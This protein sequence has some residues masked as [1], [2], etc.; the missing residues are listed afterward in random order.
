M[1]VQPVVRASASNSVR[2]GAVLTVS[3]PAGTVD[4]D[5]VIAF[6]AQSEDVQ[7]NVSGINLPN[8][9]PVGAGSDNGGFSGLLACWKIASN[10][11]ATYTPSYT[12]LDC[13][14]G[15][16][17]IQAG[18]FDPA[19]PIPV[20]GSAYSTGSGSGST[21]FTSPTVTSP[22]NA[23]LLLAYVSGGAATG[24][25]SFTVGGSQ[26]ELIDSSAV[27]GKIGME[28]A[29]LPQ[30]S[31][32]T[33]TAQTATSTQSRRQNMAV[34]AIAPLGAFT[35]S[36]AD[37]AGAVDTATRVA[38]DVRTPADTAGAVDTPAVVAARLQVPAD[39]GGALDAAVASR[40]LGGV[41]ADP[42]GAADN[43]S[44]IVRTVISGYA[45]KCAAADNATTV[46][47]RSGLANYQFAIN[48]EPWVPFG[49]GQAINVQTFDMGVP[50]LRV[51]DQESEVADITLM[52]VD[53]RTPPA[54]SWQ[55]NTDVT[56]PH[57]A[58]DW[59]E[60]L[61]E[62]WDA[63]DIRATPNAALE[64]MYHIDGRDRVVYGRPR[65]F[66]PQPGNT[67]QGN[68]LLTMDFKL[69]EDTTYDAS[70]Q[71]VTAFTQAAVQN[72][73]FPAFP[74]SFPLITTP[75][76]NGPTQLAVIGGRRAT[77]LVAVFTGPVI[78]PVLHIGPY[79]WGL[80]GSIDPGRQVSIS[81]MPWDFGV[82]DDEGR[83][84]P[85]MLDPHARLS[86]LRLPPG[87]YPVWLTGDNTVS[88]SRVDVYWRN[89]YR[90]H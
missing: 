29:S 30:A 61:A 38:A 64:L 41:G 68:R 82:V 48:R 27:N 16:V 77:W 10:E 17:T 69:V 84:L 85:G 51:Q 55:C 83:F 11:P 6:I 24:T 39:T 75:T 50:G 31:A 76:T 79:A 59:I 88:T 1:T 35:S 58:L 20:T 7:G 63:E 71:S 25:N 12:G 62:L 81:G 60:D 90:Q 37:T 9:N 70:W 5:L 72:S 40:G 18:T 74:W 80:A 22:A 73:T 46:L 65:N 4:G 32:G 89:A 42:A 21:S 3:K 45:D 47:V 56:T 78:N 43:I 67:Q 36:S 52:G 86:Q 34:L 2:N 54:W 26:T 53:Y 33:T 49:A 23:R 28:V 57:E 19:T 15:V 13:T 14:I 66:T 87:Q 8:F 44:S